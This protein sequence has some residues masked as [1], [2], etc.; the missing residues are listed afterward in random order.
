MN[1][2]NSDRFIPTV[3]QVSAGG[4]VFRTKDS[5]PENA[6]VRVVPELRWQ[7]PKGIIDPGETIEQAALREVREES[8]IEADLV[9]PI[10]TIEY[11]F[12]ATYGG[13][14]RRYHKFVH[15]FLMSYKAGDVGD[16]DNEVD[17][18]RWV[19]VETALSMLEFKSERDV[20]AKAG[21]LIRDL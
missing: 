20:V 1:D 7:L 14:R 21:M 19:D 17:E 3:E 9:S 11:W 8:G 12:V 6:I 2:T 4:V 16:H 15:F 10:E 13:R 5:A 18:S